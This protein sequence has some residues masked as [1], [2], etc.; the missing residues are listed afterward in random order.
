MHDQS[1]GELVQ[2]EKKNERIYRYIL[3]TEKDST[4]SERVITKV[5]KSCGAQHAHTHDSASYV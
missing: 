5:L 1:V 4:N 2:L 3:Y